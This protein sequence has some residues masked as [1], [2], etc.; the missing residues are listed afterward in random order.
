MH[1]FTAIDHIGIAVTDIDEAVAFYTHM[2]GVSEWEHIALPER[3]MRVAVA[4][5]GDSAVELIAPT[6]ADAAF[7]KYLADKGPGMH[8]IAYRVDDIDASLAALKAQGLRLID[9]V[10]RPGLHGTR[11]AFVHPKATMGTLIELVQHV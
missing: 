5:Y 6:S 9:E 4:R 7:A 10:A 11:V 1:H 2:F 3:A 8:H